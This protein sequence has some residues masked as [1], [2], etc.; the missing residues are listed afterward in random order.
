MTGIQLELNPASVS[1][2]FRPMDQNPLPGVP[3]N[4]EPS[5]ASAPGRCRVQGVPRRGSKK[6]TSRVAL[7][8][9]GPEASEARSRLQCTLGEGKR[10]VAG[11][12]LAR[13]EL[14]GGLA[15]ASVKPQ[16]VGEKRSGAGGAGVASSQPMQQPGQDPQRGA[17]AAPPAHT[18]PGLF[19][20]KRLFQKQGREEEEAPS[21][22]R[23]ERALPASWCW[24][25]LQSICQFA[26][27]L[28]GYF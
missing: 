10:L 21:A 7:L 18:W 2:A 25:Y 28:P 22:G 14:L 26:L 9:P 4:T 13:A 15:G 5:P 23:L 12:F 3:P 17:P 1:H 24:N 27:S 19:N 6:D 8:G 20:N 11:L 16:W